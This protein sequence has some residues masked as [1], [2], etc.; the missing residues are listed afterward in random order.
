MIK[1]VDAFWTIQGEGR[2]AGRRALFFRVPFCNLQCSWCDTEFN[3]FNEHKESALIKLIEQEKISLAVITGGEPSKSIETRKLISLL[4]TYPCDIAMETN[5]HFTIP[6]GITWT[7]V[8]PKRES[9]IPYYV[10]EDAFEKAKEFKYVVDDKFN[11]DIL[12]RH[13]TQ[14]GRLYYLS[15]EYGNMAGS[16][17]KILNFMRR[18]PVWR[19]S[20]QTHKWIDVK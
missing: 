18:E 14:D 15:P 1:L 3:T 16:V 5:G 19:L 9:K 7:T 12:K 10:C 20:L 2:N 13:D 11:F 6:S 8:S 4:M 17:E